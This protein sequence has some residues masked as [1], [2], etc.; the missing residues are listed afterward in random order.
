MRKNQGHTGSPWDKFVP[1]GGMMRR[2]PKCCTVH[3]RSLMRVECD[4]QIPFAFPSQWFLSSFV[5][6]FFLGFYFVDS[7]LQFYW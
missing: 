4:L 6:S 7:K 1:I 3:S 5:L 2:A